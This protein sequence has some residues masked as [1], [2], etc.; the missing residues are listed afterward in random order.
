MMCWFPAIWV[1]AAPVPGSP[2]KKRKIVV[3]TAKNAGAG[4]GARRPRPNAYAAAGSAIAPS[5][6]TSLNAMLYGR[7]VSNATVR[8]AGKGK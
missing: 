4:L 1:A 2:L 7:I 6:V 5:A 8:R 3:P